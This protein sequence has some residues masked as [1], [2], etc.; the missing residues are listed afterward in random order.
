MKSLHDDTRFEKCVLRINNEENSVLK[1]CE[2]LRRM[3]S[4]VIFFSY[5][6]N[7]PII[8]NARD[9]RETFSKLLKST[10]TRVSLLMHFSFE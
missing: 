9:I 10:R 2:F 5:D 4:F 6:I 8:K 7:I 3:D 1:C